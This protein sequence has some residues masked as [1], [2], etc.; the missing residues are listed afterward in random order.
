MLESDN[1]YFVIKGLKVIIY[2]LCFMK[3]LL[4]VYMFL[5]FWYLYVVNDWFLDEEFCL[6]VCGLNVMCLVYLYV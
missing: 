2:C 1:C 4:S 5:L 6:V 3:V